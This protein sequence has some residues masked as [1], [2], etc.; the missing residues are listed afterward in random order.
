MRRKLI[1]IRK[2]FFSRELYRHPYAVPLVALVVLSALGLFAVVFFGGTTIG[3]GDSHVV[4]LSI[5]GQRESVP[6]RATT[7]AEFLDRAHIT[8]HAGDVVEPSRDSEIL[9]DNFRINVYRAR[10]VTVFDG[11]T[12][13]R[14]LS[15]AQ[16]PRAVAEQA[17]ATLY[18]EDILKREV[19]SNMLK[20]QVIGEKIVI[21][22]AVPVALNLYGT[23]TTVRTHVATV[24]ELLQEKGVVLTKSD[25]VVPAAHTKLHGN[26]A[27]FVTRSGVQVKTVEESIE[28]PTEYVE[29]A[30]L[31][32][33]ATA[34]RQEGK[35]GK[36]QVTYE[37]TLKNGKEVSR[38]RI[39][40]VRVEEPVKK[41]IARGKAFDIN[42]D[43]AAVMAAAGISPSDY[44]YVDYIIARESG[45]RVNATNGGTWGLCQALP[46]HKMASA[47]AD[48]QTNPV[49]QL[50]WCTGY[51]A[52]KGGWA[53]SYDLWVSKG[54]W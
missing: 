10:P 11:S 48:W 44:P 37:I 24:G 36:Q 15:A 16:A 46:G 45:W 28:P 12:R 52:G 25:T 18:P 5:E 41:I 29:D 38:K 33:G 34:P 31:S 32:F 2:H 39:Q 51:A 19:S 22:R 7:V 43:K 26:M 50:R 3:P 53:A 49:T 23:P 9:A 1:S 20:D 27:V 13:L 35:P 21:D 4:R 42:K 54:W 30:S 8:I 14:T 17:G 47:G 6:T 40:T